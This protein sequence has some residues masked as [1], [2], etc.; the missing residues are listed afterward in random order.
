MQNFNQPGM[1]NSDKVPLKR[2]DKLKRDIIR[3][4]AD[5]LNHE[6]QIKANS[7][8][9]I[10]RQN[11][12]V[13]K[14]K[15]LTPSVVNSIVSMVGSKLTSKSQ[16]SASSSR[17][18]KKIREIHESNNIPQSRRKGDLH[19]ER[20]DPTVF[21]PALFLEDNKWLDNAVLDEINEAKALAYQS[22][23][24]DQ[25]IVI[26]YFKSQ[27]KKAAV[28]IKEITDGKSSE[29]KIETDKETLRKELLE[30]LQIEDPSIAELQKI[31]NL[32]SA[33]K[34]NKATNNVRLDELSLKQLKQE[35]N[36]TLRELG[37]GNSSLALQNYLKS[38]EFSIS[39]NENRLKSLTE[40]DYFGFVVSSMNNIKEYS[41][42]LKEGKMVPTSS[43]IE[44][45]E[46]VQD[47]LSRGRP[48]E[49]TG[50]SGTGK[51]ELAI[52]AATEFSQK[53]PFIVSISSDTNLSEAVG[54]TVLKLSDVSSSAN[55]ILEKVN[56]E[57]QT[58]VSSK[59]Y[60]DLKLNSTDEDM[61]II[62]TNWIQTRTNQLFEQTKASVITEF[63]KGPLY[64]AMQEGRVIIFDE[65]N[66]NP[67]ILFALNH[68]L[69]RKV[70][71]IVQVQQSEQGEE[72]KVKAG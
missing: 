4:E 38:I 61:S 16:R 13:L 58:W 36:N 5:R 7:E 14:R 43:V 31:S 70:N 57:F 6:S 52:A 18:S 8:N 25:A 37:L 59:E 24:E 9:G 55:D 44:H 1:S 33:L 67:A 15:P 17:N 2:A 64:R 32:K 20:L 60:S 28:K 41:K 65:A 53:P 69:T 72:V 45:Q 47:L 48:I 62:K 3:N 30:M 21:I 50:P 11:R 34:E 51:T 68:L 40:I 22:T 49:L 39:L 42:A 66:A 12:S 19:K 27:F 10:P 29:S 26:N 54:G 23:T 46:R 63:Q 35:R 56:S 71:D